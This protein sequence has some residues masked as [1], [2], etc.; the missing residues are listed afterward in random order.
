MIVDWRSRRYR[1]GSRWFSAG[2]LS[3]SVGVVV[4]SDPL[5]SYTYTA[6]WQQTQT[7]T[8]TWQRTGTFSATWQRTTTY[9][10]EFD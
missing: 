1:G 10:S 9:S 3:V 7:Y 2:V 4:A 5:P 6:S 8:A